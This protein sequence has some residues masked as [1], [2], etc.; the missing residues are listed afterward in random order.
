MFFFSDSSFLYAL[1]FQ[2]PASNYMIAMIELHD[3]I[4]FYLIIIF[5][6]V[7]WIFLSALL[8]SQDHLKYLS[9]GNLIEVIWTFCPMCILWLIGLPSLKL[10]YIMDEILNP[11]IS[12]KAIAAQWFWQYSYG[13]YS[14]DNQGITFDSF[15][16]AEDDLNIGD[17]RQLTVD[18]A[19]I[20]PINTCI[21]L[22][23]TSMDVIHSFAVPSLGVKIDAMPGRLNT[24]GFA[25]NR[26][27]VLYGQCSELCGVL[28]DSMP[29]QI[30]AV[31]IENYLAFI[32]TNL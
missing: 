28:H 19:L 3:Y 9:H 8:P 14:Q 12:V 11:E 2:D 31:S 20:L 13:D 16:I 7:S 4:M 32:S 17:F 30:N 6:L 22:I 18:N 21:R 23:V 27:T 1:G 25:I 29:I 5:T 15:M 24:I 26:P 10:L